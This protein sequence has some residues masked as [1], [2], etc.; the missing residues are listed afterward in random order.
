VV[1]SP[2]PF[3]IGLLGDKNSRLEILNNLSTYSN[4]VI[5]NSEKKTLELIIREKLNIE[6]PYLRNLKAILKDN[7][8]M[9]HY[10]LS[11]II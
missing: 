5:C 10:Y 11:K 8:N 2:V 3:L 7:I 9:A 1:E 6:E 4:I